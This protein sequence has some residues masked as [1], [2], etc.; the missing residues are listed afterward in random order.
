RRLLFPR[1]PEFLLAYPDIELEISE[2]A[3]YVDL[4]REGVDC[5][6]R[7]GE[8]RDSDL[9]ARGLALLPE[10]TAASPAYC[11]RHGIPATPEDLEQGRLM[12]GFRSGA[13]CIALPLEFQQDGLLLR[14]ALPMR[15]RVGG[16]DS[17]LGAAL[18]GL[19]IIQA[20]RYR[21]QPHIAAGAL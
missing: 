7:T 21:L 4:V 3:H 6:I 9:L 5:A 10:D 11:E 16:T 1:L 14:L 8:L 19:V 20:P 15:V 13:V 2:S 17:Y 12:M 18:A